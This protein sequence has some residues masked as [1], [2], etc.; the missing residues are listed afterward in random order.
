MSDSGCILLIDDS[1]S[2]RLVLLKALETEFPERLVK[3]VVTPEDF[4]QALE[5]GQIAMVVADYGLGWSA[6]LDLVG[7]LRRRFVDVPAVMFTGSEDGGPEAAPAPA[8]SSYLLGGQDSLGHLLA[9]VRATLE[10]AAR[11]RAIK[12]AEDRYRSL[13]DHV[14]V[15]LYRTTPEGQILDANP[16]FVQMLG[17]PSREE[18]LAINAAE[19][20]LVSGAREHWRRAMS[21]DGLIRNFEVRLRRRDGQAIWVRESTR[22]IPDAEGRLQYF[23]GAL[24]DITEHKRTEEALR[25]SQAQLLHAQKLEAVGRLAGGIAHDF[26]NLLMVISGYSDLLAE[27]V[28]ADPELRHDVDEVVRAAERAAALTQQ[29]LAF[30]RRQMMQPRV[31]DLNHVVADTHKMLRRLIGEDVELRL[32]TG[33]AVGRVLA[34]PG[35]LEQVILNLAINARDAMPQ[36]GCLT[37]ET[38]NVELDEAYAQSHL[39]VQPGLYVMLA[40]TDTGCGMEPEVKARIFEPFFTTKEQGRGSGLGLSTV[41][42][43]VQQSGGCVWVYSEPGLGT[44]FK[45]YLP[46]IDEALSPQE[47]RASSAPRARDAETVLVVEDEEKVRVLVREMLEELGYNVLEAPG[48]AEALRLC[49]QWQGP[50]DVLLTDVVMPGMGGVELARQATAHRPRLKIVFM[51]GYTGGSAAPDVDLQEG[52]AFL[53]KPFS[54]VRLAEKLQELLAQERDQV[55]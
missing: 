33:A 55:V 36:G 16:T 25:Q 23:E 11:G 48:G 39:M 45:I 9:T 50:I 21:P 44:T 43:I 4:A 17:Y 13:F 29:L 35:Q 19:L 34:D 28:R 8:D 31:L 1:P 30:S 51:S 7:V 3:P 54:Y 10:L 49:S 52:T 38:A 37:L 2:E 41:Y 20:Y 53:E 14:P 42:G 5:V 22:A 24:E 47:V 6:G 12:E 46:R 27:R 40:V 26:N 15:G 32:V 18:L